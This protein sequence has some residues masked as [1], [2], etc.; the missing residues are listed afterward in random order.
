MRPPSRL[1]TA[2]AGRAVRSDRQRPL[3][4][5][6]LMIDLHTSPADPGTISEDGPALDL[7]ISADAHPG[8]DGGSSGV[9]T[10]QDP[11]NHGAGG[12]GGTG[13]VGTRAALD[14]NQGVHAVTVA[15]GDGGNQGGGTFQDPGG[16][17]GTSGVG[18]DQDPTSSFGKVASG[19]GSTQG[20]GTDQDPDARQTRPPTG[21]IHDITLG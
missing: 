18:T 5:L 17:G 11:G 19:E 20:G 3:S 1:V 4:I 16:D 14:L 8:G 13:G 10:D 7:A 15:G 21:A 12:D 9:G 2:R 6:S